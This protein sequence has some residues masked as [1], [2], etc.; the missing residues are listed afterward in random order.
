LLTRNTG[1]WPLAVNR[2]FSVSNTAPGDRGGIISENSRPVRISVILVCL[3]N[4]NYP[5]TTIRKAFVL[6]I[7]SFWRNWLEVTAKEKYE[8]RNFRADYS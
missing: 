2:K 8:Y 1:F 6:L 3:P 7:I 4:L 5:K